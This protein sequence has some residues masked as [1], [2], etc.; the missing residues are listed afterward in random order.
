MKVVIG[1]TRSDTIV[2]GAFTHIRQIGNAFR[3]EGAEVVYVLGGD[4]CASQRLRDDGFRVMSLPLLRRELNPWL[5]SVVLMQLIW[6]MLWERPDTCSWHTAKMGAIGRVAAWVTGTRCFYVAHGVPF[7]NTPHNKS[8]KLYETLERWL[9]LLP[10][11]ILCVCRFDHSEYLRIGVASRKLLTIPNGMRG[12]P[13]LEGAVMPGTGP[14]RFAT[15][16]RFETQKDYETLGKACGRLAQQGLLFEL[17]VF[18]DGPQE[19]HVRQCFAEIPPGMIMF[20]GVVDDLAEQLITFDVFVLCSRWEGL[21][22]SLIEAM[23]CGLP[24]IASDVGGVSELIEEGHNGY[25]V[26]LADDIKFA[27]AMESY[28]LSPAL[29]R[30]HGRTGLK[31]YEAD[32]TL[33]VMLRRYCNEYLSVAV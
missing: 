12:K 17:H 19:A 4:G 9:A 29:A 7:I 1:M 33:D 6:L 15:A 14:L 10:S 23:A 32:Y 18:G 2:A 3:N 21:P 27:N 16:A 5:D 20:R 8:F 25:L 22:R 30:E 11:K 31:K 13:A 26:P 28:L 24:V